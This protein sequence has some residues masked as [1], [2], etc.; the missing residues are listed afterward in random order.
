ML[1][2]CYAFVNFTSGEAALEFLVAGANAQ[3][4]AESACV[5]E[6][7]SRT[8]WAVGMQ[9][10]QAAIE[11]YRDSSVMHAVVP[12]QCKPLLIKNGQIVSF[13]KPTKRIPKPRR[14]NRNLSSA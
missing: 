7:G 8:S 10:L 14:V 13:P 2:H 4:F 3:G 11:K 12:D 5:G 6:G 1:S 9:G